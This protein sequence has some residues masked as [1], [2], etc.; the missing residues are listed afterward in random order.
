VA[1]ETTYTQ[2]TFSNANKLG[3]TFIFEA[4]DEPWLSA[5]NTWGPNWGVWNSDGSP[6]FAFTAKKGGPNKLRH[7]KK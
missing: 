3:S 7:L 2:Q 5:Q 1:N 4:F 6:K